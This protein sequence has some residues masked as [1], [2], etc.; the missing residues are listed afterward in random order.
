MLKLI[1]CVLLCGLVSTAMAA[2]FFGGKSKV[3]E[4][5]QSNNP[6]KH[7]KAGRLLIGPPANPVAS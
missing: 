4:G 2:C 1:S 6:S 3:S 5:N 7:I